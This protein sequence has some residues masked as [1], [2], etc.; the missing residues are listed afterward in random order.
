MPNPQQKKDSEPKKKTHGNEKP[1]KINMSF[2]KAM[3]KIAKV[4]PPEN[5]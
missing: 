2:D 3:K 4:K 1:L 5:K